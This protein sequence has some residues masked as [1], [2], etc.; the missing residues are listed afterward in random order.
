[1]SYNPINV[2]IQLFGRKLSELTAENEIFLIHQPILAIDDVSGSNKIGIKF[3]DYDPE[4][5]APGAGTHFNDL[6]WTFKPE[7]S[8]AD[9]FTPFPIERTDPQFDDT[10]GVNTIITDDRLK[11]VTTVLAYATGRG[12]YFRKNEKTIDPSLGKLTLLDYNGMDI[13]DQILIFI[14]AAVVVNAD[15]TDLTARVAL[16]EIY[17]R[18]FTASGAG[19]KVVWGRAAM[20]I[21]TGWREWVD[22]RGKIA[23]PQ[24]PADVYD[25]TT[26]PQALGRPIGATGGAK[27]HQIS[28]TNFL[29]KHRFFTIVD[30]TKGPIAGNPG[31]PGI[32]IVNAL[33]SLI[34]AF[35]KSD[36][37]GKESYTATGA[38]ADNVE[39]TLS[40]TSW[41][42][43][44]APDEIN[45]MN[46]FRIVMYIEP[47]I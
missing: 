4:T 36:G 24:D 28:G 38:D 34:K 15:L 8:G 30:Q 31:D 18:P 37:G 14:P 1:M 6:D 32:P 47:D 45:H 5:M 9:G 43:Q 10:D 42:G 19:G 40:P 17:A 20:Y 35:S 21:P 29:P 46:P 33:R 11:G 41:V 39:P 7:N 27:T 12:T 13:N 44:T 3:G 2:G 22:I 26:N 25:M 16:L 23:I